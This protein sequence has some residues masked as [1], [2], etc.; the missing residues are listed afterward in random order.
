MPGKPEVC[1]VDSW[2][3]RAVLHCNEVDVG[4]NLT[5]VVAVSQWVFGFSLYPSV[6]IAFIGDHQEN[7]ACIQC[8]VE[9]RLSCANEAVVDELK[10]A[11]FVQ[12]CLRGT[13]ENS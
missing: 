5:A 2:L 6:L 1:K 7:P 13:G 3:F 9:K 8:N 4:S 12:H 10:E 11:C